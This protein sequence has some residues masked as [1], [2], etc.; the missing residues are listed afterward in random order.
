MPLSTQAVE[1]A[2]KAILK[3]MEDHRS[4]M[5]A[6]DALAKAQDA[7]RQLSFQLLQSGLVDLLRKQLVVLD[8]SSLLLML[9]SSSPSRA[10]I[11]SLTK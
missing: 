7:H 6:I 8:S 11:P 9:K 1:E 5:P 10:S 3:A 2:G 4:A